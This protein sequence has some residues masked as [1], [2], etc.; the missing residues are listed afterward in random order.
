[1]IL[2]ASAGG[3]KRAF[4]PWKLGLRTKYFWKNLKLASKFR[5]IDLILAMRVL[6]PLLNSHCT[7]VRFTVIVSCSDELAVHSCLLL[8]LQRGLRKLRAD[9]S[10]VGVY[11]VTTTWQQIF[12][13]SLY[14]TVAGVLLHT[15]E[16]THLGR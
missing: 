6:L 1:M 4:A 3:A 8:C 10:A 15:V 14:I 13:S 7:R 12:K 11:C 16:R 2:W 9:C 5:L